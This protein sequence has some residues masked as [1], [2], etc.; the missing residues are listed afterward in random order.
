MVA[1]ASALQRETEKREEAASPWM[2]FGDSKKELG[3]SLEVIHAGVLSPHRELQL[4]GK[5]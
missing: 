3:P 5:L 4:S 2:K 1:K